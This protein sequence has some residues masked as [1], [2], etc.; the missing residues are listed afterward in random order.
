MFYKPHVNDCVGDI[1]VKRAQRGHA[2][3][4]LWG[5][6]ADDYI[7]T[8]AFSLSSP[9]LAFFFLSFSIRLTKLDTFIK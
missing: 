7:Q 2:L 5:H 3:H 6:T 9:H 1:R 4:C 8:S